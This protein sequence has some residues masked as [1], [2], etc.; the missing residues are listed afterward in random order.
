MFFFEKG[1]KQCDSNNTNFILCFKAAATVA[2][3]VPQMLCS[4]IHFRRGQNS[5]VAQ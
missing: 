4:P 1:K 3:R 2:E 5:D